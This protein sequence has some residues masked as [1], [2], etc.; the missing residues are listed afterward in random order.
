MAD[1]LRTASLLD[2]LRRD[3]LHSKDIAKA[4]VLLRDRLAGEGIPFAVIGALLRSRS[5]IYAYS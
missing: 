2:A 4:L 5:A 1:P 3:R